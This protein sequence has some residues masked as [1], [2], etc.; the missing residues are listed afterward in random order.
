M[1]LIIKYDLPFVTIQVK[2]GIEHL[3]IPNVLIDTGSAKSI[4][5][6]EKLLCIGKNNINTV[7][8]VVST[9]VAFI[10]ISL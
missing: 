6:A 7:T 5:S 2:L 9:V 8:N 1:E 4:L 3:E 10:K